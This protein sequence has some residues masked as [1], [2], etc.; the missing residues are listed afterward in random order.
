MEAAPASP[1]L[2]MSGLII[3]LGYFFGGLVPL[4]PYIFLA[5]GNVALVCSI[6]VMVFTLFGFGFGKTALLGEQSWKTR[7]SEGIKMIAL[8]GTAAIISAL[9][10]RLVHE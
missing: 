9:C 4:L 2:Y 5:D 1:R 8:G 7:T 6:V 10:V 3:A